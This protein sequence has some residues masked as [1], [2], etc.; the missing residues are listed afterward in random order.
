M[1][2]LKVLLILGFCALAAANYIPSQIGYDE[3][4]TT[5]PPRVP[6]ETLPDHFDWSNIDGTNY[7][8]T[9]FNQHIPVYCGAC[10]AF[11]ATSALSDRIKFLRKAA[12]PDV[13]ISPQHI[14][15][16]DNKQGNLGCSGG[17]PFLAYKFVHEN[18]AVDRTC[19][20]YQ[21]RGWT[22]GLAC[23]QEA[24]CWNC[25]HS[26][27]FK[28]DS[29]YQYKITQFGQVSGEDAMMSEI[30]HRGPIACGIDANKELD[31]YK[32]GILWDK[33][34]AKSIDH[35]VSIVGWGEENGV[36]FWRVRNSWGT[37]WGEQGYFRIVRGIDNLGIEESC[38]WAVPDTEFY[39]VSEISP[40]ENVTKE[41]K[42]PLSLTDNNNFLAFNGGQ[43]S[44]GLALPISMEDFFSSDEKVTQT[45]PQ[46]GCVLGMEYQNGEKV[47]TPRPH[48]Y[49]DAASLP[50]DFWWG[51]VNGVNYLSWTKNQHIPVYCGSCWAQSSTSAL[52]DRFNIHNK[53]QFPN[54][55]LSV[56]AVINCQGGGSCNGGWPGQVYEFAH[57]HGIPDNTC[58]QYLA[59]NPAEFSCSAEQVCKTCN[60]PPPKEGETLDE[61]CYAIENPPLF[62][63]SEYGTVAGVD[64]MKAEIHAR[65]PIV[66]GVDATAELEGYT[67]GIFSQ[68][69]ADI[70]IN[71]AISV[72][73][74]G[75]DDKSNEDYWIVRN[76]WGTYWG[77]LGYFRIV[78]GKPDY[79]LGIE[80]GCN[81]A[82]PQTESF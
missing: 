79:N 71:H 70:S 13:N 21:A 75:H 58:K 12:F 51:D 72:V 28:P 18:G 9:S 80:S 42:E 7:L 82:V 66:C 74:W 48:E 38:A 6:K 11:A 76:S 78:M 45:Q 64:Q 2:S 65:G 30:F 40:S 35:I 73:G 23:E 20:I 47:L 5:E 50:A 24:K 32:G 29:F 39:K 31:D 68:Y 22:N 16:C 60:P 10:W 15:S 61:N 57:T 52:A 27:C 4:I 67:G 8:T 55:G 62:K 26:G 14:L 46:K 69:L 34:G 1:S 63:V 25:N 3:V 19:S 36:K 56:Q 49:I 59:K 54:L 43:A 41:I 17:D 53:A 77:E 81:W 44:F 33:T 37:W